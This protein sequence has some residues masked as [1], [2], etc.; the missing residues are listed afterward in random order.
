MNPDYLR[1]TQSVPPDFYSESCW[2]FTETFE[3]CRELICGCI[4][5]HSSIIAIKMW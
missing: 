3:T 1:F 4:I 2:Q 5:V